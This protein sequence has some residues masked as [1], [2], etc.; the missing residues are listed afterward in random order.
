MAL[1]LIIALVGCRSSSEPTSIVARIIS[2]P[3]LDGYIARDA[4]GA[5]TVTQGMTSGLQTVFAGIHPDTGTEYRAFLDFSL[6]GA[7]GVPEN[8]DVVSA[9]IDIVIDSILP[10]PMTDTIPIRIDLVSV[11]PPT[12]VEAV[13]SLELQPPL[14]TASLDPPI[15]QTALKS[16][17]TINVTSMMKEAQRLGLANFQIRILEEP[18]ASPGLIEIID[19]TEANRGDIAPLLQVSYK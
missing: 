13:Y 11:Q 17:L 10:Q 7:D 1:F 15:S 4:T 14:Y 12:L 19:S 6:R 18:E 3:A 2:E 16:H 9:V 8:A 5:F